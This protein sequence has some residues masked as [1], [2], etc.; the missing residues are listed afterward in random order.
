MQ[1]LKDK[2]LRD[3]IKEYKPKYKLYLPL[4]EVEVFAPTK[5]NLPQTKSKKEV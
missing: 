3:D 1:E 5:V 2:F 4:W